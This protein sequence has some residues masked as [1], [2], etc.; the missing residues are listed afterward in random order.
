MA[1]VVVTAPGL[2]VL[3]EHTTILAYGPHELL[4]RVV[5]FR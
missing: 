4:V 2:V 5:P 1:P 3:V